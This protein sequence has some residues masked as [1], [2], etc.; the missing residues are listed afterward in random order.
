MGVVYVD[1]DSEYLKV[2]QSSQQVKLALRLDHWMGWLP[3]T[4]ALEQINRLSDLVDESIHEQGFGLTTHRGYLAQ[5]T[6]NNYIALMVQPLYASQFKGMSEERLD[7]VLS[8]FSLKKCCQ[9][10]G[11]IGVMKKHLNS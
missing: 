10:Q 5:H 3:P 4:P 8:S 6:L 9:R 2:T 1:P 7:E 11:S